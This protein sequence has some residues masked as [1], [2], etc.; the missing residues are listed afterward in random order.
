MRNE[1]H[2]Y[3]AKI[4]SGTSEE[5]GRE[6]SF[7]LGLGPT[8]AK[9]QPFVQRGQLEYVKVAIVETSDLNTAWE[10]TNSIDRA[11]V[12][13]PE[14]NA[15]KRPCR[16]SSTGDIFVHVTDETTRG[17]MVAG[18]GFEALPALDVFGIEL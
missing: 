18:F 1:I 12:E 2:V 6:I 11:W 17:H 8:V 16:S 15:L 3:H 4:V 10:L 7:R 14:V 13:N 5:D 9:I